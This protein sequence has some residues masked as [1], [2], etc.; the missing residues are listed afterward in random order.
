MS[1]QRKYYIIAGIIGLVSIS[2][3]VLFVQYRRLMNYVLGVKGLKIK[4]ITDS[5]VSFDLYL[6]FK[7]NSDIV[8]DIFSQSY[9]VYLNDKLAAKI[10]NSKKVLIRKGDNIVPLAIAFNPKKILNDLGGVQGLLSFMVNP[11]KT[12]IR[13]DIKLYVKFYFITTSIPFSYKT[14]IKELLSKK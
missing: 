8:I 9:S 11:E 2:A 7:N 5:L 10:G 4:T 12:R 3:A 13:V 1:V 6:S 14:T